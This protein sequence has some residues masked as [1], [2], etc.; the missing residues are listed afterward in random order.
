MTENPNAITDLVYT[1]TAVTFDY[2][3]WHARL[4]QLT[5][6]SLQVTVTADETWPTLPAIVQA[7]VVEKHDDA[8]VASGGQGQRNEAPIL[9]TTTPQPLTVQN[10]Q[11]KIG[12]GTV[13]IDLSGALI[14]SRDDQVIAR[15]ALPQLE[16]KQWTMRIKA[17]NWGHYF[18]GGTQNGIVSLNDRFIQIKNENRWTTG[19]VTSPVPFYWGTCGYGILCNTFTPG[20]YDFSTP[21]A[22]VRVVHEGTWADFCVIVEQ[23]PTDLI[24]G[25]HQLTGIPNRNPKF[26]FYPAHFNAYNRDF[27]VP[28]TADSAAA[29]QYPNG[30]W[31]KEYQPIDPKTFNTGYR[32]G[33]I[34][35]DGKTLVPN[36]YGD[37]HVKFVDGDVIHETLNGEH[38]PDFSARGVIDRYAQAGFPLGWLLPNDGYGAGYGQTDSL[39][40]DLEN[41]GRFSDYAKA[42]GVTTGLWTQEH[43]APKDPAAPQKNERDFK[44][45]LAVGVKAIKTDVAWVGEG[46]TFGLNATTTASQWMTAAGIRPMIVTVDGWAGSQRNAMV[47]TGD[48]DGSNWQNIRAHVGSYLST[49]LSGNPNVASDVDGIYGGDDPV[50]Q[51]RD[52]QW[53]AFTPSFFA[54]DGWGTRLKAFGMDT[55]NAEINRSFLQYHTQLVPYLYS[56]AVQAETTGAPI[57]RP[58]WWL[59]A[60][61]YTMGN[62]LN[63]QFLIGDD[64]LIAP[65][66]DP[67]QLQADGSG[68]RAHVYLPAGEW[69]DFW[70]GA[71]VHGGQTLSDMPVPL[72]K[73]PVFVRAGAILPLAQ[74]HLNPVA[75]TEERVIDYYPG[76]KSTFTLIEDDG[77][78]MAYQNGAQ[79]TTVISAQTQNERIELTIGATQGTYA[80]MP[81]AITTTI[82]IAADHAPK[83]VLR[84]DAVTTQWQFGQRAHDVFAGQRTQTG[85]TIK[86]PETAVNQ[87]QVVTLQF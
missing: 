54:M 25:Y 51:T 12:D 31:Y 49:G 37:G 41:L 36:V 55:K 27:W 78:T 73:M 65:V 72:G 57:M 71:R 4:R 66:C 15:I 75:A 45:E 63:D 22:G 13:T 53:K 44:R 68:A 24:H 30:K 42:H 7:P 26:A 64:L 56:L 48:Q 11:L 86:L 85:V 61:D 47:W 33:T 5:D 70:T 18:G 38:D 87:A 46:Y 17:P 83:Q 69:F 29:V 2:H 35:V 34:T 14:V 82:F 84:N 32:P 23:K 76:P 43:L 58:T 67:Y 19:G 74:P 1:P 8:T 80:T 6:R 50:I 62:D 81:E 20:E 3:G 28:V 60:N 79:A 10:Q 77:Q 21:H 59:E 52:L 16:A 9:V 40:G 39:A